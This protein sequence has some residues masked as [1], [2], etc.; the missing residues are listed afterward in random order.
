MVI[1]FYSI[2]QYYIDPKGDIGQMALANFE[3]QFVYLA[4]TF[5]IAHT[6]NLIAHEV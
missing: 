5:L 6:A 4:P 1:T 3:W 2:Y